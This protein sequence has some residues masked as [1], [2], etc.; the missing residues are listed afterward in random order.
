MSW[1]QITAPPSPATKP[2]FTCG[3]AILACSAAKLMSQDSAMVAPRPMAGPLILAMRACGTSTSALIIRLPSLLRGDEAAQVPVAVAIELFQH[4]QALVIVADLVLIGNAD[5]AV[6][7]DALAAD[8]A[9][10]RAQHH[11]GR[12]HRQLP[13]ARCAV[14]MRHAAV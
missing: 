8:E 3:S 4:Q 14:Q 5:A 12:R 7:L 11:L 9:P 1:G 13:R 2:T 6:Q 10:G